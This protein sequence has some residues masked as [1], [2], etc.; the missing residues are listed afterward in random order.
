MKVLTQRLKQ[1]FNVDTTSWAVVHIYTKD[2]AAFT[3]NR[4]HAQRP[5]LLLKFILVIINLVAVTIR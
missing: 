3:F 5:F 4:V 1:Y 2:I